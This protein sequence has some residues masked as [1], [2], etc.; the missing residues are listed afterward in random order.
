VRNADARA[1]RAAAGHPLPGRVRPDESAPGPRGTGGT[2]TEPPR[3]DGHRPTRRGGDARVAG[4][5]PQR[6]KAGVRGVNRS[7]GAPPHAED[8]ERAPPCPWFGATNQGVNRTRGAAG[9]PLGAA[10]P[11]GLSGCRSA[12]RSAVGSAVRGG[13]TL[14][15]IPS[16]P[17]RPPCSWNTWRAPPAGVRTGVGTGVSASRPLHRFKIR[18]R[19][20]AGRRGT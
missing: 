2:S 18:S 4:G 8:S 16:T 1:A 6:S 9:A 11:L 13:E 3:A 5:Q 14:Q 19:G 15:Q 10:S 17:M 7:A 12:V 20:P